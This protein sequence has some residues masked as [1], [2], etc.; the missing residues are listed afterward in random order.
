MQVEVWICTKEQRVL[1]KVSIWWKIHKTFYN[2][3]CFQMVVVVQLA[4]CVRLH[5]PMGWSTWGFPVPHHLPGFA[6]THAIES[7]MLSSNLILPFSNG[8]WLLKK[9]LE[10]CDI[11]HTSGDTEE[12]IMVYVMIVLVLVAKFCLTLWLHGL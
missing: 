1:H 9:K 3:C 6:P 12:K 4:C 7:V 2:V 10:Q 5:D 8:N 11:W